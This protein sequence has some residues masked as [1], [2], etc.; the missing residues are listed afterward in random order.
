MCGGLDFTTFQLL[1]SIL[2]SKLFFQAPDAREGV[3]HEG[4]FP[5]CLTSGIEKVFMCVIAFGVYSFFLKIS[6]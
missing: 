6:I 5:V 3:S 1:H 2:F 4:L